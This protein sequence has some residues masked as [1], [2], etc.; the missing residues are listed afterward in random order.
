MKNLKLKTSEIVKARK[1]D[2]HLDDFSFAAIEDLVKQQ[3]IIVSCSLE[4]IDKEILLRGKLSGTLTFECSRCVEPY[5]HPVHSA[6]SQIYPAGI[7]E[8]DLEQEISEQLILDMPQKP[9][10][11]KDCAGLCPVCGKNHNHDKCSCTTSTDDPRWETLRDIVV[12]KS[13][14]DD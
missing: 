14:T 8:I 2:I 7:E 3:N 12:K 4:L 11:R 13:Q 5:F 6:V 10:C 1:L 9:L